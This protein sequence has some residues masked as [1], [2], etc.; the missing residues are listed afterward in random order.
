MAL[1]QSKAKAAAAAVDG[2]VQQGVPRDQAVVLVHRAIARIWA[3]R[4]SSGLGDEADAIL[5]TIKNAGEASPIA[6]VREAVTPWLFA[7][8]LIGFA[9]GLMNTRR[10]SLMF[11]KWKEKRRAI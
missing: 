8:S 11:S 9:M 1:D 6:A 10:I 5:T 2:L 3:G 4:P 7:T